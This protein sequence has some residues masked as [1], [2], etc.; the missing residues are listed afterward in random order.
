MLF[1]LSPQTREYFD[2]PFGVLVDAQR[3]LGFFKE[4]NIRVHIVAV[5]WFSA[6]ADSVFT[7][8]RASIIIPNANSSISPVT[9]LIK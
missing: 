1:P 4:N 2:L 9:R 8:A 6:A 7:M 5:R 3:P